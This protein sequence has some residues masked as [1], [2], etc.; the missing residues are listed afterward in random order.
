LIRTLAVAAAVVSCL[1]AWSKTIRAH[2]SGYVSGASTVDTYGL[3]GAAGVDLDHAPMSFSVEYDD[4]QFGQP[5]SCGT[6]CLYY[7]TISGAS[8]K[9]VTILVTINGKSNSY[10]CKAFGQ[11]LFGENGYRDYSFG[12]SAD[13]D[14]V[15]Q[16]GTGASIFGI[17][18]KPTSFGL[19]PK[20]PGYYDERDYLEF[21]AKKHKAP[22]VL[23]FAVVS[24]K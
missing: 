1:P 19:K 10:R 5:A 15:S 7:D 6:G 21:Y 16:A 23:N 12:A 17:Y 22:E 3:F 14:I 20:P 9:S 13:A 8:A 24:N 18:T 4:T 11:V 2:G